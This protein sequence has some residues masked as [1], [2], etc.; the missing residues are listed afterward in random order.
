MAA[1]GRNLLLE[2][3]IKATDADRNLLS[4]THKVDANSRT[5]NKAWA[6]VC[7][8]SRCPRIQATAA[9]GNVNILNK[10]V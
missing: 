2:P 5:Q 8:Q 6:I 10:E 4:N 9:T 3:G 7:A 1:T